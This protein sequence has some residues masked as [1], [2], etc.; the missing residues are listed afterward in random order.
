MPHEASG[1]PQVFLST[2]PAR[3]A[4]QRLALAVVLLSSLLFVIAA[5]FARTPLPPQPVFIA[6]YQAAL[7]TNDIVTAA[8]LFGQYGMLRSRALLLLASG[9]L[10]T[11]LVAIVHALT[12]PGL[13]APAGLLGA[14]M[15]TTAWLYMVWH[16]VFPLAVIGYALLARRESGGARASWPAGTAISAS[17]LAAVALV[18]GFALLTTA[19]EP[20]LPAIMR[21]HRYTPAMIVVVTTVWGLS[22]AALAALWH[23]Q[24]RS[25]LDLWLMVVMCA[26]VF[27][28]GLSAVLN[29]GRFDLGFYAGRLYGLLASCFVLVTLLT[30]TLRLYAQLAAAHDTL[31]EV[32]R[33][34]GLTGVFNRRCLDEALSVELLRSARERQPLSM[35]LVDVDHFKDFNDHHGHL[36]GDVCLRAVAA[37][38]EHS[39]A[40][41]ADLVARFGGE[42]F[43][44]LLPSTE[45][46][47]ALQVAER[48]KS[49]VADES[50]GRHVTVSVG[51]ATLWPQAATTADDLIAAADS[52]LYAAKAAGRNR[53][54]ASTASACSR[55]AA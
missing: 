36:A 38:I 13:F 30:Q 19:G 2:V 47:G 10:F 26:W 41:P 23:R 37:S 16:G 35:L 52:A 20:L 9:Y 7:A 12:F 45:M 11:A 43:A 4:E 15:Q 32:A 48:V 40:R 42:E 49:M 46:P 33:R 50:N 22:V 8:L 31:R 39:I 29:G 3:P 55:A 5:P 1:S 14:G 51:V 53:V 18:A 25:V 28:I 24:P 21:D 54:A 17:A 6:V 34:D 27:D 44:V